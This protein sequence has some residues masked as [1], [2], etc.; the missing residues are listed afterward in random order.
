MSEHGLNAI[1]ETDARRWV[2]EIERIDE[3]ILSIKMRNAAEQKAC[4]ERKKETFERAEA[5]GL[6]LTA[7]KL[8]LFRRDLDRKRSER[9]S[10]AGEDKVELADMI[11]TA[12]SDFAALPL[13]GAAVKAAGIADDGDLRSTAQKDREAARKAGAEANL[14]G[15][16]KPRGRPRKDKTPLAGA[17]SDGDALSKLTAADEPATLN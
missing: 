4:K 17:G 1:N 6:P 7:L 13:G 12:L 8:E 2:S 16:K 3:E 5:A 11:R 9:E 15:M 14:S 10:E